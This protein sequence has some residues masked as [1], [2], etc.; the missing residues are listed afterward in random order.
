MAEKYKIEV[1]DE[2]VEIMGTL[3]IREAFDFL[4]FYEREGYTTLEDWG[5]RTT[6]YL[7]KRDLEKEYTSRV[8][9]ETLSD[10]NFVKT[11]LTDY[12][13][14]NKDLKQ[15]INDLEYLIKKIT[16]DDKEKTDKLKEATH[17]LQQFKALENLKNNPEAAQIV[18]MKEPIGEEISPFSGG[19]ING[20]HS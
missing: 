13:Q 4:N 15:R 10:L 11:R 5:E 1:S 9:E 19:N 2:C 3:T 20:S 12:E 14:E 7:R 6:L 18:R 17:R 16:L 8:N